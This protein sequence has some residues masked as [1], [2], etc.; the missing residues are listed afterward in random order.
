MVVVR[1]RNKFYDPP[2][3]VIHQGD[4]VMWVNETGGGWHGVISAEAGFGSGR[5]DPGDTFI[6]TFEEPGVYTFQC[7]PHGI[8]GMQGAVV[9]LP[10]ESPL[11]DPLPAPPAPGKFPMW[12]SHCF[13]CRL[14]RRGESPTHG[15]PSVST[16]IP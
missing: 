14:N 15:R 2:V 7:S 12:F 4:S 11:P 13:V 10:K 16:V 9:V 3:V 5:M 1:M 6:H 8:D